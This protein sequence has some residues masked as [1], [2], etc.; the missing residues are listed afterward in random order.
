[1]IAS[2]VSNTYRHQDMYYV[3]NPFPGKYLPNEIGEYI[4]LLYNHIDFTLL[5]SEE[6]VYCRIGPH[7]GSRF[8]Y[9][10]LG[11]NLISCDGILGATSPFIAEICEAD[12]VAFLA[13]L[14]SH[15]YNLY[16]NFIPTERIIPFRYQDD[17]YLAVR[18]CCGATL[19]VGREH[20]DLSNLSFNLEDYTV[21]YENVICGAIYGGIVGKFRVTCKTDKYYTLGYKVIGY[22]SPCVEDS[23][24][25]A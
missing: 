17:I 14:K 18:N 1:M 9:K 21:S 15:I 4:H 6:F 2:L 8:K 16:E 19:P 7:F 3:P 13:A 11:K 5:S 23:Y 25:N 22:Q 12:I 24:Y 20:Y 10:A